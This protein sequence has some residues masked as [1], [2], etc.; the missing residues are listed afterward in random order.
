[1][2]YEESMD[3]VFNWLMGKNLAANVQE[4]WAAQMVESNQNIK[5][6]LDL[7]SSKDGIWQKNNTLMQMKITKK[8]WDDLRKEKT[9]RFEEGIEKDE[10]KIID[11]IL[12]KPNKIKVD[13]D[14][15]P[16]DALAF[17]RP[18]HYHPHKE[19]GIYFILD[20]YL[21]YKNQLERS[22]S[23]KY[24]MFRPE[25]VAALILFEVFHHEYY[26]HLVE[27]TAFT[28][29][30]IL[31]EFGVS[32]DIYIPYNKI[33]RTESVKKF[34]AHTPLEEA[35]ANAYA[36]NSISFARRNMVT[37]NDGVT[38]AY[39]SVLKNHWKIEPPG[40]RDAE[41]YIDEKRIEGNISLLKMII[42]S[43]KGSNRD[44][45]ERIVARVMPSGYTSMVPKPDIPVYFIG[46][47]N[48]FEKFTEFVPNPRAAYAYLE[49]PFNTDGISSKI[50]SEKE[51]RA[52]EKKT[53]K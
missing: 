7:V 23:K 6:V 44:A 47:Q 1:M 53:K 50:K 21:D 45:I 18:F 19:W 10:N 43:E 30:T 35:L 34:C 4:F 29:E 41:N 27:S 13:I 2:H 5:N 39:Q 46:D 48:S 22:L 16:A 36:Y 25:I 17:Y 12:T 37:F 38:K 42:G 24:N 40:Y 20:K 9:I 33:K 51:K 49:F 11:D 32:K 14:R 3:R 8:K 31:A 28:L 15:L 26:H 52:K